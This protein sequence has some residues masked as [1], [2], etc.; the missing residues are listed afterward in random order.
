MK[1]SLFAEDIIAVATPPGIGAIGVI[2]LSGPKCISIVD[3]FFKGQNLKNSEG[4]RIHY[5]KIHN[6]EGKI[7]DECLASV[8]KAP[9]SYTKEDAI[10]LS[11]H[12]SPFILQEIVRLFIRN[13][14]RL[15]QPGE[16]TLRA[17]LNGQ[18]DLT[19]A[20]AVADLISA[21]SESEHT[22]AMQQMRGGFSNSLKQ[23][24]DQLIEFASLLELENDF[25]EEDVEF[26]DRQA[27]STIINNALSFVFNLKQSFEYGNAI[28]EGIPVAIIGNP[29]VGKS[30][31]LNVLLQEDRA[32]VSDI[33]GT[34]RDV[35]EDTIVIDGFQFRFIDTAGIRD[36]NDKVENIG[37]EKTF[38]KISDA[39]IILQVDEMN[40]DYQSIVERIKSIQI[41]DSQKRIILLNKSDLFINQCSAYDVEEAVST[42]MG[43]SPVISIAANKGFGID[44]L[45]SKLIE[46]VKSLK[47]N[48]S[49]VSISNQRHYSA[50]MEAE[51]SLTNISLGLNNNISSDFLAMDIRHALHHIGEITGEITTDDLLENIFSNFCIGK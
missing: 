38:Q 51:N 16:F 14:V 22:I 43:R 10:E 26:A 12:G 19:Q 31:L 27:L 47:N 35:I 46:Q 24:K 44:R 4:H 1:S 29:N 37:I 32:I 50:L 21:S 11:C 15:A 23:L 18:L 48:A 20:E 40:D 2:R 9:R 33:A 42:L 30:T 45:K 39:K 3:D 28:K 7:L 49:D 34:T 36:T 5:G 17:F 13:G 6:E 41:T 25:G 8:F